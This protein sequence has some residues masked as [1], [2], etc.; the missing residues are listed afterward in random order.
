MTSAGVSDKGVK[1]EAE[2]KVHAR[3]RGTQGA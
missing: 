2:R 3:E 1:L